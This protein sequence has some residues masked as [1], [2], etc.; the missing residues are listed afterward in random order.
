MGCGSSK[1]AV[2]VVENNNVPQGQ[3]SKRQNISLNN[4]PPKKTTSLEHFQVKSSDTSLKSKDKI[5]NNKDDKPPSRTGSVT[6][7][8]DLNN[9]KNKYN[10]S[11]RGSRKSLRDDIRK[12]STAGSSKST[13]SGVC[14]DAERLSSAK[15]TKSNKS[16]TIKPPSGKKSSARQRLLRID[17]QSLQE[18]QE[19]K[20]MTNNEFNMIS[21]PK[22]RFGNVAFDLLADTPETGNMKKRPDRLPALEERKKKRSK[23]VKT[24]EEIEKKMQQVEERR[25]LQELE[26]QMKAK[27]F[28]HLAVHTTVQPFSVEDDENSTN[29]Q[30]IK[31]ITPSPA[32]I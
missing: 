16:V 28:Q 31:E 23:K 6:S 32:V 9:N 5:N 13:D 26:K 21:R 8:I 19:N 7:I 11:I 27:Q 17:D 25:K 2:A 20:D 12:P 29:M 24:K 15:S 14:E 4:K 3:V 18:Q 30:E 10:A 1:A 22:S